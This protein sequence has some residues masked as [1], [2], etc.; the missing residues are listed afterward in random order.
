MLDILNQWNRWGTA[1]LKSGYLRDITT[2]IIPFLHTKEIVALVGLR[3]AGKTTVLYQI[4]DKLE[5]EGIPQTAMLHLNFEEPAIAPKLN[6]EL[7][8]HIYQTYREEVYPTGKAYLFFDEIQNVPHWEKW[9][10]AR[11]EQEEIKIFIT[12]SSANLMSREL[13]TVLT[14]RHVDFYVTPFSFKEFLAI[15]NIAPPKTKLNVNPPPA[16]QNALKEYMTWGGF[17]EV[18]LSEDIERKKILLKQYFDDI[19][20]KDIAMR[21]QVRDLTVLRNIAVHL[22]TQTSCLF[23]I[24]RIAKLFQIS[25]EMASNYCR[26]IQE[27]FLVDYLPYFSLKTA[28]RNRHSQKIHVN[29]LGLRQIASISLS[30]DYGKLTETVVYQQLQRKFRNDIFYWKGKQE[31]DFVIRNGN[32]IQSIIQVA[33][34]N[35]DDEKTRHRELSSL[36]AASDQFKKASTSLIVGKIPKNVDKRMIPLWVFLLEMQ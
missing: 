15:K 17:P 21:H 11:N 36:E 25:L 9:V 33:Y 27:T 22:M 6:V 7:L 13:A 5:S 28:E 4:M 34:D 2:D 10:R 1:A 24:N 31:T 29:D 26:F 12:G 30:M 14:G 18:A 8:D 35:L 20:F 19:L 32:H 23:S 3:R 16:I